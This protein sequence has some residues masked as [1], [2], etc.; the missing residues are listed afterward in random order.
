MSAVIKE[1][2]YHLVGHCDDYRSL[3]FQDQELGV[4]CLGCLNHSMVADIEL[5]CGGYDLCRSKQGGEG[6]EREITHQ[7]DSDP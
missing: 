1:I 7:A 2:S 5:N 3:K 6:S 4:L